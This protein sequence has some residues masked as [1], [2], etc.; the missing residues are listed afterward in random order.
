MRATFPNNR[1]LKNVQPTAIS[2]FEKKCVGC[3]FIPN[4]FFS[5]YFAIYNTFCYI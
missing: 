3:R 2:N 1:I 5:T 4:D